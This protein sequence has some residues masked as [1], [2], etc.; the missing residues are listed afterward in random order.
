MTTQNQTFYRHR[1][2]TPS[3]GRARQVAAPHRLAPLAAHSARGQEAVGKLTESQIEKEVVKLTESSKSQIGFRTSHFF[4][5]IFNKHLRPT[6]G[7][8]LWG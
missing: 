8:L 6:S 1:R 4:F 5:I 2:A 3:L 7:L